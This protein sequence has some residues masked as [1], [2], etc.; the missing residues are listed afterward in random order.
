MRHMLELAVF[1]PALHIDPVFFYLP[2]AIS[3]QKY[4]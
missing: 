4:G 1:L 2:V 3:L